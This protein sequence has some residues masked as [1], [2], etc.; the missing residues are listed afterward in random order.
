MR[1]RRARGAR[2]LLAALSLALLAGCATLRLIVYRPARLAKC[3]GVLVP[4]EQIPDEFLLH[5]QLQVSSAS[6]ATGYSLIVQK[7]GTRLVLVALTRF[8]AKAFSVVQEGRDLQ[9]ESA[10]GP[11]TVV[12]PENVLRD[13]HRARFLTAGVPA[14]TGE[15]E[16]ER[17]GETIRETW[18]GGVLVRRVFSSA[19]GIVDLE[20]AAPH[21]VHI[22]NRRCGY[23]ATLVDVEAAGDSTDERRR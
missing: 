2:R 23:E 20:F 7:T 14:E 6:V 15:S 9:V 11:A 17:D 21:T 8:G 18:R 12:P 1:V 10:L 5:M 4:S 16:T 22:H 3:P 19:D 13:V